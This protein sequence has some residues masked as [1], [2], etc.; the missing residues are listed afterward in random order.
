MSGFEIAGI[1]LG[2]FPILLEGTKVLRGRYKDLGTWWQFERE[3]ES[4]VSAVE[5]EHIAFSQILEI[6]LEPIAN[7]AR[8]KRDMLLS[9]PQS[10][11]WFD[12]DVQWE[13]RQRIQPRYHEWFMRQLGAVKDALDK[14]H[15]L[16]PI[17]K[18][19]RLFREHYTYFVDEGLTHRVRHITWM[20]E[21]LKAR[22]FG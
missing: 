10:R 16:L 2:G 3:F 4:F 9:N 5:R 1:V 6:L 19:R 13:L 18:V 7:L 11:R 22:C 15:L 8:E 21:G 12:S 20:A 17:G 14:V